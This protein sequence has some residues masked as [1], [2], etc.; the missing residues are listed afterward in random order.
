VQPLVAEQRHA[1][2]GLAL[3]LQRDIR[4][5]WDLLDVTDLARTVPLWIATVGALVHHYALGSA[6]V[7][8]TF[9]LA[10]RDASGIGGRFTVAYADPPS[11]EL[12]AASLGFATNSLYGVSEW[13][14]FGTVADGVAQRL[15]VDTGR[16]TVL[17]SVS[18]D[19]KAKGWQ[20]ETAG[21]CDFCEMLASRGAVYSEDTA[22]FEAHDHCR[23]FPA[24]IF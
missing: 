1:Q 6:A 12:M 16:Q 8:G 4:K 7:A 20:R 15:A 10:L 14:T 23:C 24:P 11:R 22:G 5:T 3:L 21:G 19:G 2:Y 17:D 13:D 9:Y 18:R